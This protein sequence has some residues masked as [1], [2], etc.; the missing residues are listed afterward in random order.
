[1]KR[2][3]IPTILLAVIAFVNVSATT[4]H[5]PAD[6]PTIQQGIDAG[7]DGDTVLVQP[8]TYYENINFNG[9]N[10]VLGSL[11]LTT[12]DT[13]YIA[14]TVIDGDSSGTVV[15]F[16]SGEDTSACITG[17]TVAN[18]YTDDNGGG[19]LCMN[20]SNPLICYNII[21]DN[22][23]NNSGAGICCWQSSPR[24]LKNTISNNRIYNIYWGDG[25]GI[26]M[27]ESNSLIKGNTISNNYC[28]CAGG[29]ISSF[30]SNPT[31]LDNVISHNTSHGPGGG[32]LCHQSQPVIAGN[33]FTG[34]ASS[35]DEGGAA[36]SYNSS[37][38]FEWNSVAYNVSGFRGGGILNKYSDSYIR[39]NIFVY[40]RC[41]AEGA[42]IFC[43]RTWSR[44]NPTIIN[45]VIYGNQAGV[46]GGAIKIIYADPVI[47][48]TIMWNNTPDEI[49]QDDL[50]N[51]V[52]TYSNI[53][54]GWAGE[55]NINI[56]P[57]FRDP[58]GGDF[59]LQDSINC[60][61]PLYSP[62]IDTGSPVIFDSLLDCSR[63]LGTLRSDMGAYGGYI[64]GCNYVVGDV[65]G[66]DNYN[67]LDITY[68]VNF[69]KGGS[70]PICDTCDCPPHPFFWVCGD[71]NGSCSY[72]GLDITYGV[73]FFKGG[74]A[75]IP[76]ADCPPG[77][78]I[79]ITAKSRNANSAIYEMQSKEHRNS[80][81][82]RN[83]E[84]NKGDDQLKTG[85]RH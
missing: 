6:Y 21:K 5:V 1:M 14:Q 74:A 41:A 24:I 62:C 20:S 16:V 51:P 26:K 58:Q 45:N 59:H 81:F 79:I 43:S 47:S 40:N 84:K 30:S 77:G 82:I 63:G 38:I 85:L 23:S 32:F 35:V 67:G 4:I 78:G 36:A 33:Q 76:C 57:L 25:G 8:G 27:Y 69:F 31:I 61:D 44:S 3:S 64:S 18:G 50:S 15:S 10:I 7:V 70:D 56:D 72:N 42:A 60:G 46:N 22:I 28:Y 19:I 71:V 13:I 39:N 48:N 11:F 9:H 73:N 49:N 17:F 75:P 29:G 66:S 53:Q 54:G 37:I 52:I 83:T 12:G 55:G 80:G 65:N 2:F 68:G 34:N